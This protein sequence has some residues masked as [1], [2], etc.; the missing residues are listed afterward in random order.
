[1]GSFC[2]IDQGEVDW[3]IIVIDAEEAE[4]ENVKNDLNL[5][6]G[7]LEFSK[8]APVGRTGV[9]QDDKNI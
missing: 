2:L 4:K 7:S 9:V 8:G 1:M 6:S 5:D 3:K